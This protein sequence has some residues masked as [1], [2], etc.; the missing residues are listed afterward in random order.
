MRASTIGCFALLLLCTHHADVACQDEANYVLRKAPVTEALPHDLPV[1]TFVD[2]KGFLWIKT[3]AGL[4]R[5]DGY[6]LTTLKRRKSASISKGSIFGATKNWLF[7]DSEGTVWYDSIDSSLLRYDPET[8]SFLPAEDPLSKFLEKFHSIR[9]VFLDSKMNLWISAESL[10]GEQVIRFNTLNK[11]VTPLSTLGK[12][13]SESDFINDI[14]QSSSGA[15]WLLSEQGILINCL[16]DSDTCSRIPVRDLLEDSKN[17]S[18][19]RIAAITDSAAYITTAENGLLTVG[20]ETLSPVSINSTLTSGQLK[21]IDA[22]HPSRG[23]TF[24]LGTSEGLLRI[25]KGQVVKRLNTSNSVFETNQIQTI[26]SDAF[27]NMYVGTFDG[28]YI[29]RETIFQSF[30]KGQG[31][32]TTSTTSFAEIKNGAILVSTLEGLYE[33]DPI[34]GQVSSFG[35]PSGDSLKDSWIIALYAGEHSV[36]VGY[37]SDGLQ[38]IPIPNGPVEEPKGISSNLTS[39]SCIEEI[40]RNTVAICT[41]DKGIAFYHPEGAYLGSIQP[42]TPGTEDLLPTI[43]LTIEKLDERSIAVGGEGGVKFLSSIDSGNSRKEY[44][45]R[46]SYSGLDVSVLKLDSKHTLWAG[47][48]AS[49]LFA[50]KNANLQGTPQFVPVITDPPLPD[51]TVYAILEDDLGYMWISTG[52]GLVRLD[53]STNSIDIYDESDGLPDEEFNIDVAYKDSQGYLYFGG[54]HGF[55]RFDPRDFVTTR[56]PPP[57]RLTEIMISNE[58][59]SYDPVYLPPSRLVLDHNDHSVDFEFSTMDIISPGRSVYKYMLM[60]FDD[61]WIDIGRRNTATFTSLPAGD[62]IF[63]VIGA[64]SDGVWNYDGISLPIR[65]LPAPWLTW[66]AFTLYGIAVMALLLLIKRYYETHVLKEEATR[67]AK[68]MTATA[69][70]AMDELQDQLKVE[71][72]LV[73]NLRRH[74]AATMDTIS[75]LLAM[76][77]EEIEDPLALDTMQRTRQRL[78]CLR[79]L[80]SGVYFHV[81]VLKVNFRDAVDSAFGSVMDSAPSLDCEIV[82]AN[83]CTETLVPIDIAMPLLVLT[84]E[85]ILNSV[86]HAFE[87]REGIEC[88]T[89]HLEENLETRGWALEVADTGPGLPANIDPMS[90]TTLGMELIGRVIQKL[91]AELTYSGERGARFRVEVPGEAA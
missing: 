55:I 87:G 73:G 61:G 56:K 57:L 88:I 89:V 37:Y 59:V 10:S 74:A 46:S 79:A 50:W 18:M 42:N 66:W 52:N 15:V 51:T 30:S 67:Q 38:R 70:H 2:S 9:T 7:E 78:Q 5:Y 33:I 22:V 21:S 13:I 81:D 75:E 63:R 85:L 29:L 11:K 69:T 60:G 34:K 45:L 26:N 25:R 49:G 31:L 48:L 6:E 44:M 8:R 68:A 91:D 14:Y 76:E 65:V 19:S 77:S 3:T 17:I 16:P 28:L 72:R 24:W 80:E 20:L 47:A 86:L 39:I 32:K 36:W 84:H 82:L 1:S 64:N 58:P 40:H 23:D 4:H 83:D 35:L 27:G 12:Y 41:I 43:P 71:Q 54:N 62:Y 53:P 90:P